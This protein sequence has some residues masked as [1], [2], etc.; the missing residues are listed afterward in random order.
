MAFH[1]RRLARAG[2]VAAGLLCAALLACLPARAG[3]GAPPAKGEPAEGTEIA[4]KV[5]QL[6]DELLA[7]PAAE[8]GAEAAREIDGLI[9][10]FGSAD[11]ATRNAASQAIL[12]HKAAALGPLRR[13]LDS[14]D[15]EVA[16]RSRQ[17]IAEI[18]SGVRAAV[19]E[20]VKALGEPGRK[21]LARRLAGGTGELGSLALGDKAADEKEAEQAARRAKAEAVWKRLA[22]LAAMQA[23]GWGLADDLAV[24][25]AN[26]QPVRLMNVLRDKD[27]RKRAVALWAL[28]AAE[29]DGSGTGV[30]LM[31]RAL[32]DQ[33][34]GVRLA[35]VWALGLSGQAGSQ[36]G[37][38]FLQ[39]LGQNADADVR[40]AISVVQEFPRK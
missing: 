26:P 34:A 10:K 15:L 12:R 28:G 33:D 6:Q 27:V 38:A 9:T 14:K 3:E 1:L 40:K 35:L 37:Q 18:T 29:A 31:A 39:V 7:P 24:A 17:A 2:A 23:A 19:F 36:T 8:P 25:E 5:Q 16:N 22:A 21:E 13:A 30:A 4:K 32:N 20:K 11:F